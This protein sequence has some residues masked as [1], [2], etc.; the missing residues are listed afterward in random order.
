MLTVESEFYSSMSLL[1]SYLLQQT[2]TAQK[3]VTTYRE[4]YM[5]LSVRESIAA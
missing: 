1:T 4:K 3:V 2:S 5:L